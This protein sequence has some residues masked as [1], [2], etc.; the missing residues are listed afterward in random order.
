MDNRYSRS[1]SPDGSLPC[2]GAYPAKA[3]AC[4]PILPHGVLLYELV[5]GTAGTVPPAGEDTVAALPEALGRPA[6][7]P[8]PGAVSR[9]VR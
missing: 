6:D 3:A 1:V 9:V 8:G 5:T 2:R 4:R 7:E